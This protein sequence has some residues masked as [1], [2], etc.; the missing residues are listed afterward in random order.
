MTA[1]LDTGVLLAALPRTMSFTTS[2]SSHWRKKTVYCY[3][4]SSYLNWRI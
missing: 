4:M 2:Q 1:L 3:P